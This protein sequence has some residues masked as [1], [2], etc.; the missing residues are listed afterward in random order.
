MLV[1]AIV[2]GG[3][4][5]VLARHYKRPDP[6][7]EPPA[8]GHDG[9]LATRVTLANDAPMW[10]VVKLGAAERRRSRTGPI[11][12][13]RAIVFDEA[14]T[15]RLGSPLAGR[16]TAVMV[17]RGQH[18]KTGDALFTVSSPNLAELRAELEKANVE[19]ATAKVNL[20][21]MKALVDAGSL[22]GEGA[23]HR[24]SRRSPRPS[25]R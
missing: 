9:R 1:G 23:G 19:R 16:V 24:A 6:P 14:R 11:R 25:S 12:S 18:V 5:I 8:P 3:A 10:S 15:S 17:E 20:D 21:R 2:L 4:A 22:P 7:T 13:R